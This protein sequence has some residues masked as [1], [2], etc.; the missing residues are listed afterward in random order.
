MTFIRPGWNGLLAANASLVPGPAL[1]PGAS[2]AGNTARNTVNQ[3]LKDL[4][5]IKIKT[6][7]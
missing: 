4:E 6:R 7:I 1:C 2:A 3:F 5:K